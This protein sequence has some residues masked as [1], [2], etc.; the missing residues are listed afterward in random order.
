MEKCYADADKKKGKAIMD[1]YSI[2]PSRGGDQEVETQRRAI[3]S[4]LRLN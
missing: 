4:G 1:E 2:C 3:Q